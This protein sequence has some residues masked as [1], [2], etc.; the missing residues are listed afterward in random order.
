LILFNP[1]PLNPLPL[2]K[3]AVSKVVIPTKACPVP[4]Y[5]AVSRLVQSGMISGFRLSPEWQKGL[6]TGLMIQALR[7]GKGEEF[8]KRGPTPFNAPDSVII[9]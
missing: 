4:R 9:F 1:I 6:K 5:E 2:R 7:K 8:L 3:E